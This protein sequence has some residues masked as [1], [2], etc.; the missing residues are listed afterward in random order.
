M[1]LS[2]ATFPARVQRRAPL[3][4]AQRLATIGMKARPE[5]LPPLARF[6][7]FSAANGIVESGRRCPPEKKAS[8]SSTG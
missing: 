1:A 7:R 8:S 3:P 4:R 2:A 5:M 6:I